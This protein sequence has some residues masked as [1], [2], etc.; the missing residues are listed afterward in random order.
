M[1]LD[2]ISIGSQQQQP[3]TK[4]KGSLPALEEDV[5][6]EEEEEEDEWLAARRAERQRYDTDAGLDFPTA[7]EPVL[8]DDFDLPYLLRRI[9]LLKEGDVEALS[10]DSS[11]LDAAFAFVSQDP[12]KNQPP[13][14]VVGRPPP[15][16]PLQM[17]PSQA[18]AAAS[19]LPLQN[20]GPQPPNAVAY[21]QAQQQLAAQNQMRLQQ[22]Q[23]AVRKQMAAAAVAGGAGGG[24]GAGSDQMR[25]TPSQ[26]SP[27]GV[28]QSS[29][30][31]LPMQLQQNGQPLVPGA[32]PVQFHPSLPGGFPPQQQHTPLNINGNGLS[33]PPQQ[34][35][36]PNGLAGS[37]Q[38]QHLIGANGLPATS[39]LSAPPYSNGG[40]SQQQQQQLSN[41]AAL[42][43]ALQAQ[44]AQQLAAAGGSPVLLQQLQARPMSANGL[45]PVPGVHPPSRP[46]S[47]ASTHHHSPHLSGSGNGG[48]IPLPP[49]NGTPSPANGRNPQ[50]QQQ[51]QQGKRSS[52]MV[53]V[54]LGPGGYPLVMAQT[55]RQGQSPMDQKVGQYG[56]FVQG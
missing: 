53:P 16:P 40:V 32:S 55:G 17:A 22:Q 24:G 3:E 48:T 46:T 38:S 8:L 30:P 42:H 51:Q 34:P 39:R 14:I 26:G 11:Y 52:P 12:D 29:M 37:P 7:D 35:P 36:R 23:L 13:P 4:R 6:S 50:Q 21:A 31:Q 20:G 27:N 25:R 43:M 2:R 47:A 28:G 19:P 54:Q 9:G 49:M 15:R 5:G 41:N 1:L 10:L 45:V 18:A 33:L 56:G 44:Q